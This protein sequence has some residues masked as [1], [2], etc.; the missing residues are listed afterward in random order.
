M[1]CLPYKTAKLRRPKPHMHIY[2][3]RL[4]LFPK[5]EVSDVVSGKAKIVDP[6]LYVCRCGRSLANV[7]T[8][9]NAEER[10]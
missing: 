10:R 7:Q 3:L 6:S 4:Y 1:T 5:G 9:L 2:V 8:E